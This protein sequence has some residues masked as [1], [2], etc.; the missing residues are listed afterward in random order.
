KSLRPAP[1]SSATGWTRS[2]TAMSTASTSRAIAAW[3][4]SRQSSSTFFRGPKNASASRATA[5]RTSSRTTPTKR[6]RGACWRS[7]PEVRW[8]WQRTEYALLVAL[9]VFLPLYEAPKNILWL[10]YLIVWIVNRARARDF[11]GRWDVWDT[12]ITVWVGSGF[13][14]AAFAGLHGA[15]WHGT[16]DLVRYGALLFAVRRTRYSVA[17]LRGLL[18]ALVAA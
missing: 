8:S 11:G 9:C 4:S 1:S 14:V 2:P 7:S 16:V 15:E 12:L 18:A 5:A 3:R 6:A 13:A 17:E 10:L